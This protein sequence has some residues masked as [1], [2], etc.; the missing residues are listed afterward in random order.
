MGTCETDS[1]ALVK[2]KAMDAGGTGTL[3]RGEIE[4]YVRNHLVG[5]REDYAQSG[6]EAVGA[7]VDKLMVELD[8][9]NDGLGTRPGARFV[10]PPYSSTHTHYMVLN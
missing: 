9:N 5:G 2:S 10:T 4:Q 8:T 1:T 6:Q 7:A 3:D